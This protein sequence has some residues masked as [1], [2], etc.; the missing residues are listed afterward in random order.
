MSIFAPESVK[1]AAT[2]QQAMTEQQSAEPTVKEEAEPFILQAALVSPQ[3]SS[4]A[5]EDNGDVGIATAEAFAADPF[6]ESNSLLD[7]AQH[8]AIH[9][10]AA[11]EPQEPTDDRSWDT[12]GS[13]GGSV[14]AGR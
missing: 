5:F 8:R 12:V 13:L 4:Q 1:Q 14:R 6:T 10:T 7:V 2:A 11:Y 9:G 3:E